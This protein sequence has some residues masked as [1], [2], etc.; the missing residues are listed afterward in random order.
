MTTHFAL[1]RAEQI[2]PP[3]ASRVSVYAAI[4]LYEGLVPWSTSLRSL[5]G[6]LNGLEELPGP[7]PGVRHDPIS[8]AIFAQADVL[9]AVYAD[10]A[11]STLARIDREEASQIEE[12]RAAG[13]PGE[14]IEAAREFGARLA[15]AIIAWAESDGYRETRGLAYEPPS[16]PGMWV[17]TAT[18]DEHTPQKL[19]A[20]T[21]VVYLDN[22]SAAL[23]Q[24][25]ASDRSLVVNRPKM[26]A[27]PQMAS[28]NPSRALEPYWHRVR[29]FVLRDAD[30]CAPP[31]PAPY[32][33]DPGSDFYR[34]VRAVHDAS[35]R[36]TPE[37]RQIALFWADNPGQTGTPAG[38]WF[39][40]MAQVIEEEGLDAERAAELF[41]VGAV[42][43]SDAFVSC[44]RAKYRWS[45]VRPVTAIRRLL[46]PEW[47]TAVVTPPFPEYTAGH[48]V[49]SAAAAE[50][51]TRLLGEMPFTDATQVSLGHEPRSFAS[52]RA[53]AE[54]AAISRL[55]GGIH[56]PMAIDNGTVQGTCIGTIVGERLRTRKSS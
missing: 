25:Q 32:S 3:E 16:G 27:G 18:P 23:S 17:P 43:I 6:Q 45:L 10:A 31:P 29:P 35:V 4:A 34:E 19:S 15:A 39:S 40:I 54:E 56:Y 14:E 22:P 20:M 21:E 44:W 55:Y 7:E 51:L 37:Q 50:V 38:H 52:F 28:V 30:E 24:G 48:S 42:A 1:A 26:T 36:L 49:Q 47:Q 53:A 8:A 33:E 9:R 11:P 46:D 41:A 2:S 13:V 5:A 12:R